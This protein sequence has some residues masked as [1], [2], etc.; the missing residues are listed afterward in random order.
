MRL[1]IQLDFECEFFEL[2]EHAKAETHAHNTGGSVYS[3]KCEDRANWLEKRV[4]IVSVLGLVVLP[5][6][7]PAT[8]EMP[9]DERNEDDA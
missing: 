5:Q 4:S 6:N 3:W 8:I 2:E 1:S 7:L 9:Y